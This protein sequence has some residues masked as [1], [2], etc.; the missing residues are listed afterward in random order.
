MSII[1]CKISG[2]TILDQY[3]NKIRYNHTNESTQY[4]LMILT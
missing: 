1:T 2:I 4:S 3:S